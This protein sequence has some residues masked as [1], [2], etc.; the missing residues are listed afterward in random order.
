VIDTMPCI[1]TNC[2]LT[3]SSMRELANLLFSYPLFNPINLICFTSIFLDNFINFRGETIA[4]RGIASPLFCLGLYFFRSPQLLTVPK[5]ALI[6]QLGRR[7]LCINLGLRKRGQSPSCLTRFKNF[8]R[9][10]IQLN[11]TRCCIRC[12]N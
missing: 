12:S 2:A 8:S 6:N 3:I 11:T 4:N 10:N 5:E 7:N 1:I 9:G